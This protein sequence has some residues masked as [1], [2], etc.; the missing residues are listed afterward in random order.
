MVDNG[1]GWSVEYRLR[2]WRIGTSKIKYGF[3]YTDRLSGTGAHELEVHGA[4]VRDVG[5]GGDYDTVYQFDPVVE[6][7]GYV[8]GGQTD[9]Y[10]D[11]GDDLWLVASGH[12]YDHGDNG[13]IDA[14]CDGC[15]DQYFQ[16][17]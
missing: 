4:L 16:G 8:I 9:D 2:S 1:S 5:A 13:H 11:A 6:H 12:Y 14:S 3:A 15:I 17:S 10:H 7:D